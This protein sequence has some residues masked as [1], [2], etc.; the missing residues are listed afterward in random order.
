MSLFCLQLLIPEPEQILKSFTFEP[1]RYRYASKDTI[2]SGMV[3][4][5]YLRRISILTL[6]GV[7]FTSVLLKRAISYA[8]FDRGGEW[9]I[10]YGVIQPYSNRRISTGRMRAA[11]RAGTTV[12]AMLMA[13][14]AAAIQSASKALA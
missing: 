10:P 12:A 11:E 4:T 9:N 7:R 13:S 3:Y 6:R 5:P 1:Y 2:S 8:I 14:A